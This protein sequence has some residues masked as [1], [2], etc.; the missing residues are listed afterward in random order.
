MEFWKE[1]KKWGFIVVV[2]QM[3]IKK[4][5]GIEKILKKKQTT[6]KKNQKSLL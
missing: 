3:K 1:L 4:S 5:G 2:N 6:T